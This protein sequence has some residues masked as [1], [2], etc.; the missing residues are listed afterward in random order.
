VACSA[1][2]LANFFQASVEL[3]KLLARACGH[4]HLA[5]LSEADLTTWKREV[6]HLTG[7]TYAGV[8]PL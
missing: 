2:R 6:A 4:S 8:A 3:M 7:V 1:K 5:E